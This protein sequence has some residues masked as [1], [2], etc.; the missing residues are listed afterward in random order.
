MAKAANVGRVKLAEPWESLRVLIMPKP[1]EERRLMRGG[2]AGLYS[3]Y[4]E[5]EN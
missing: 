2:G 4:R 1:S 3:K 5:D